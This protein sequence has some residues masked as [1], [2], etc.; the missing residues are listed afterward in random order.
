MPVN[1]LVVGLVISPRSIGSAPVGF[2][3]MGSCETLDMCDISHIGGRQVG[4]SPLQDSSLNLM[5]RPSRQNCILSLSLSISLKRE[6][7]YAKKNTMRS[8]EGAT[9]DGESWR[10]RGKA[11][12]RVL[13][14]NTIHLSTIEAAT[15]GVANNSA[16]IVAY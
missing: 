9:S 4:R 12:A 3:S 6:R 13:T 2:I 16:L 1:T 5:G 8:C 14:T 15:I 10:A 11:N 7:T